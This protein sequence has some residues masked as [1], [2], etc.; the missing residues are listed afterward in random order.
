MQ[1]I[2]DFVFRD[3]AESQAACRRKLK[4]LNLLDVMVKVTSF[5]VITFDI[6]R[7]MIIFLSIQGFVLLLF[8]FFLF[9]LF[10]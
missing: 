1:G 9:R 7:L 6:A 5:I 3:Q 4:W 2:R 10:F 8:V